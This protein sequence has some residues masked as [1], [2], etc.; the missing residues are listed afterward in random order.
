MFAEAINKISGGSEYRPG[1][2]SPTPDQF[3]YMVGQLTGGLGRELLKVNPV[4]TAPFT[5]DELPAHKVPVLGRIYGNTRG[6]GAQSGAFYENVR[7]LN[8][9]E[10]EMQ[11]RNK[12]DDDADGYMAREPLTNLIGEGNSQEKIVS[13][14]RKQR[15]Q[16]LRDEEPGYKDRV[17][18]INTQ[19]EEK[20]GCLTERWRG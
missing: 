13:N 2:F 6:A 10:N 19:I 7:T 11:S 17:K 14:L 1:L 5:G 8:E 9:V 4:V 15:K 20:C 16:E 12:N 3:D 18:E